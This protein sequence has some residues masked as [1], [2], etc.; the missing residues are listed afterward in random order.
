MLTKVVTD[1]IVDR[2]QVM[3]AY[4]EHWKVCAYVCIV[5]AQ[6]LTILWQ[7][8][9]NKR[10]KNLLEEKKQKRRN[11]AKEFKQNGAAG[12]KAKGLQPT[13]LPTFPCTHGNAVVHNLDSDARNCYSL[14]GSEKSSCSDC[15]QELKFVRAR[16]F[17]T[18]TKD[19]YATTIQ[20]WVRGIQG[21]EKWRSKYLCWQKEL[22]LEIHRERDKPKVHNQV[23]VHSGVM[24]GSIK[25]KNIVVSHL[26]SC[27]KSRDTV[28][29]S[30]ASPVGM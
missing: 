21:R 27:F 19:F 5:C 29:V 20:A 22:L 14:F 28:S 11:R 9:R 12:V 17:A 13:R 3:Q 6:L 2:S 8:E 23:S 1:P 25:V 7:I 15:N 24:R 30:P 4:Q 18:N 10:R 16:M 26:C